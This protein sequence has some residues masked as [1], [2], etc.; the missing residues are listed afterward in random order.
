METQDVQ[1]PLG[2]IQM[3]SEDELNVVDARPTTVVLGLP[4]QEYELLPES[5]LLPLT[6]FEGKKKWEMVESV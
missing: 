5:D 4:R 2:T 1:A 3:T 6:R